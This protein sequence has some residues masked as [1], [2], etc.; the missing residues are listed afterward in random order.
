MDRQ[1]YMD[2]KEVKLLRAVTENQAVKDLKAG[3]TGGVLRWMVVDAALSTGL[4]VGELNMLRCGDVDF[5][6]SSLTV[7]RTKRKKPITE[8]LAIGKDLAEHLAEFFE[9]KKAVD[10]STNKTAALFVSERGAFKTSQG[11][12][13]IW[14]RAIRDADLPPEYSIH[15]ARHTVA[16]H[17]LRKTK[18]L[19]QVQKQLGHASPATTA[20]MYADVSFEDMQEGMEGL[21]E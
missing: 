17:L 12:Q 8:T 6:R 18:N 16:V 13:L 21:Y 19:R 3:R 4:R 2:A 11:L 15:S 20:N 14:K 10:Q 1:K 9:W 7:T 5:K